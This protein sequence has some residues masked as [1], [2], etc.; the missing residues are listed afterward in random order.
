LPVG[1]AIIQPRANIAILISTP[2]FVMRH[3]TKQHQAA[4]IKKGAFVR[5]RL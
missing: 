4:Q 3:L 2:L 1:P 5:K